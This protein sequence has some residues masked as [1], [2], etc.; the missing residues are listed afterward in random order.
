MSEIFICMN[1]KNKTI[2]IRLSENQMRSLCEILILEEKN[3]S[4]LIRDIIQE[5]S[6]KTCCKRELMEKLEQKPKIKDSKYPTPNRL[7]LLNFK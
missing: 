5:Y 3:K 7:R 6:Q 2:S 1:K 4:E